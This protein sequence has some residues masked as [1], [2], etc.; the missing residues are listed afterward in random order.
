MKIKTLSVLG[1]ALAAML[2]AYAIAQSIGGPRPGGTGDAYDDKVLSQLHL[3]A[4]QY[5]AYYNLRD[6]INIEC[7]EMYKMPRGPQMKKRGIDINH[8]LNDG[9]KKIFTP[10]Q[11]ETYC[12]L[13]SD[14]PFKKHDS[15]APQGART[16]PNWGKDEKTIVASLNL[17]ADQQKAYDVLERQLQKENKELYAMWENTDGTGIGE[18]SSEI[19]RHWNEGIRKIFTPDQLASYIRQWDQVMAPFMQGKNPYVRLRPIGRGNPPNP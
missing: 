15:P 1:A 7:E 4:K 5:A 6:K 16:V 10:K 17:S 12:Y 2:S 9:M 3:N 14:E 8:E 19:N 11:Y 13:W 18:K